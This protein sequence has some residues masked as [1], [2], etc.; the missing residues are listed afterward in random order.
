MKKLG[1]TLYNKLAIQAEEAE[2]QGMTKLASFIS[3]AI[4]SEPEEQLSV[5]SQEELEQDVHKNLWKVATCVLKYY[6]VSS[7]DAEKL[8]NTLESLASDFIAELESSLDVNI[9]D[10]IELPVPGETK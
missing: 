2:E 8:N 5:Y 1:I 10:V 3:K 7:V 6:N 9:S 4:G